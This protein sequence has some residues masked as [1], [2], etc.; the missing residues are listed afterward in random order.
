VRDVHCLYDVK[1]WLTNLD[2]EGDRDAEGIRYRVFLVDGR[3]RTALRD[4][5]LHVEIYRVD[6][7]PNGQRTRTLVNDYH[8]LTSDVHRIRKPG[9]LGPGYFLY[10]AFAD[11]HEVLGREIEIQTSFED[12]FGNKARGATKPFRVPKVR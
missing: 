2:R 12:P 7:A 9:E 1:P 3:G 11:K 8:Y 6:P 5:T 4:G 10:L